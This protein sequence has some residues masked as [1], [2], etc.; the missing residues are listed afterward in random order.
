VSVPGG[1]VEVL[2]KRCCLMVTNMVSKCLRG[3]ATYS[4]KAHVSTG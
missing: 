3:E 2:L 1:L 4:C